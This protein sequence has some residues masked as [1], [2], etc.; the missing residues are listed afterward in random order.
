M[1]Y[2]MGAVGPTRVFAT[3]GLRFWK[4]GRDVPDVMLAMMD[5]EKS[6]EHPEFTFALRVN[7]KASV[8]RDR[9]GFR[10]VGSEGTLLSGDTVTYA[11]QPKRPEFD[12]TIDSFANAVQK[13][14]RAKWPKPDMTVEGM[15]PQGEEVFSPPP[16]YNAHLEHHRAFHTAIRGGAPVVEDAVFGMRAAGPA[17]LANASYFE[18]RVC[19][20]DPERMA[21]AR[22]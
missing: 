1:H 4:D 17:L 14:L 9:F 11:K 22:G 6:A 3:G 13:E 20:W 21:E 10:F 18:K 15:Q 5:Y 19:R 8:A 16:G 2:I 7:L 12:G